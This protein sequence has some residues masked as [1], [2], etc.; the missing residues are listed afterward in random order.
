[1]QSAFLLPWRNGRRTERHTLR[2]RPPKHSPDTLTSTAR[3]AKTLMQMTSFSPPPNHSRI[4]LS[5]VF[6][7]PSLASHT[8]G[9]CSQASE[10]KTRYQSRLESSLVCS[11]TY[12]HAVSYIVPPGPSDT[13]TGSR[14]VISTATVFSAPR[15]SSKHPFRHRPLLSPLAP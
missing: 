2:H 11:I 6:P 10:P 9:W 12:P 1:M 14:G 3:L 8:D 7:S 13:A 5:P 15:M 4:G